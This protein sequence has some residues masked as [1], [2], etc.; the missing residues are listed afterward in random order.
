[1][2]IQQDSY[3]VRYFTYYLYFPGDADYWVTQTPFIHDLQFELK[4]TRWAKNPTICSELL[5][6]GETHWKDPNGVTHRIVIETKERPRK[7]G[8]NRR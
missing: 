4:N 3:E 8:V 7:W 5:K 2:G 1:M 6:H